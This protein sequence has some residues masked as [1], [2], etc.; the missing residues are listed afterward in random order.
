MELAGFALP[1]AAIAPLVSVE[2]G[3]PRFPTSRLCGG[4]HIGLRHSYNIGAQNESVD[5]DLHAAEAHDSISAVTFLHNTFEAAERPFRYADN[6]PD[7]NR[8]GAMLLPPLAQDA[9][10]MPIAFNVA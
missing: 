10:T 8:F 1:P 2:G 9:G 7:G 5:F 4:A 3:P 6:L